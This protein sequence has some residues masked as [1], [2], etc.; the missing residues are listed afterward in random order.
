[1]VAQ[2]GSK[3]ALDASLA[4]QASDVLPLASCERQ[5][6]AVGTIGVVVDDLP[7]E[8][9]KIRCSPLEPRAQDAA[10]LLGAHGMPQEAVELCRAAEPGAHVWPRTVARHARQSTA[11]DAHASAKVGWTKHHVCF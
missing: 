2:Q 4:N 11:R 3:R 8:L 6:R 1:A 5:E 9:E 10:Y 7:D